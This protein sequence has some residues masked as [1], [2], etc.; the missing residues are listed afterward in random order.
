[1]RSGTFA[2]CTA[3]IFAASA[4]A[5]PANPFLPGISNARL[6]RR[7]GAADWFP[8]YNGTFTPWKYAGCY[9]GDVA[10]TYNTNMCSC[11][12]PSWTGADS[13]LPFSMEK[14]FAMCKGAGFRYAGIKGNTQAKSCWCGSDVEDDEKLSSSGKCDVPCEDREGNSTMKY[15]SS[16][17]GGAT[18]YSIWKDPC[19]KD[20]VVDKAIAAYTYVGCFYGGGGWPLAEGPTEASGDNLSIDS[21]IESCASK[22]YAYAGG[23]YWNQCYCGGKIAPNFIAYHKDHPGDSALCTSVC[24]A[25]AKVQAS[26]AKEDVQYCGGNGYYSVYYSQILDYADTCDGSDTPTSSSSSE[27]PSSTQESSS[28]TSSSTKP[29]SSKVTSDTD[30]STASS[31]TPSAT[32]TPEKSKSSTSEAP[33]QPT[34]TRTTPGPTAGTTTIFVTDGDDN[35]VTT[36]GTVSVIITTPA[37]SSSKVHVT[38]TVTT[39]GSKPGTSTKTGPN[40]DSII[41]TT[42]SAVSSHATITVTT[43]GPKSGVSTKTGSKTDTVI[44]TTPTTAP[45]SAASSHA[46]TTVTTPGPKLATITKTGSKTDSVIITTPTESSSAPAAPSG[47]APADS[48][49]LMP[50]PS[51]NDKKNGV[52]YPLGG[53]GTSVVFTT[54]QKS[55]TLARLS[56][57]STNCRTSYKYTIEDFQAACWNGCMEQQKKCYI[58][59]AS[60]GKTPSLRAQCD[61]QYTA[62]KVINTSTG[63]ANNPLKD[64]MTQCG[65]PDDGGYYK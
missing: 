57:V 5:A 58:V 34:V 53:V 24:S 10:L 29:T 18:T 3:I 46:T 16:M 30:S 51:G 7:A 21:C 31:E 14:C 6:Q 43:P 20:Y 41:I 11:M 1:M 44:M 27:A 39:P 17:C 38:V 52:R 37:Q 9:S 65:N 12:N 15:D 36:S 32:E 48:C 25:S 33:E 61:A 59:Y 49:C 62:C 45:T 55:F 19:F 50:K 63:K 23:Y 56:G 28:Q 64:A 26:I 47:T 13:G 2:L 40:T 4:L 22:G 42:P 60:N 35:T 8:A 54:D